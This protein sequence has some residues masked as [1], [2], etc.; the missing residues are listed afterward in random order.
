[1]NRTSGVRRLVDERPRICIFSLVVVMVS[2]CM[3]WRTGCLSEL[4]EAWDVIAIHLLARVY[5]L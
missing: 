3:E 1:L 2:L 4:K 5:L